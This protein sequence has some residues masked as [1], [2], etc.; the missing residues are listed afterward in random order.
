MKATQLLKEIEKLEAERSAARAE[1]ASDSVAFARLVG[2][3]P[4]EWQRRLLSSNAPQIL[5]NCG[6]QTGKSTMAGII[7]LHQALMRPSSLVLI[8]APAER[9][10]KE[11][12]S[13]VTAF[14]RAL[15]YPIP[16]DSYRKLGME[17]KN[18][19]RIEALPGTEKTVRGFSAV[20]LL[21]VDEASRV[22]D[23]LYHAVRPMLAVSGGR[24]LML[25]TPFGKRGEFYEAWED[26]GAEWERYE[27][28]ASQCPRISE[29]FLAAERRAMPER[30]YLQEFECM[31]TE[32]DDQVFSHDLVVGALTEEIEPLD[33]EWSW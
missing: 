24:L 30:V 23:E 14:Y 27:V 32:T 12:F 17:L 15:G 22:S 19:S 29:E 10:A 31:F 28:P 13:K 4:D 26:G 20:D 9:Q 21:L 25:S 1:V 33:L 8:L 11:L 5:I 18:G 7:A 3:E 16:A 2:I 6:R